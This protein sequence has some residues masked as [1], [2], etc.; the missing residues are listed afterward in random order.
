M[1]EDKDRSGKWILEHQGGAILRLGGLTGYTA[2]R[3]SAA[4]LHVPKRL[5]DGLLEV[6]FP[7]RAEPALVVVEVS[8]YPERRAEEQ[9]LQDALM[10][11]L[12]RGVL[13]EVITLVLHPKGNLRVTGTSELVS[14]QSCCE[15][16]FS[17]RV[18]NL[19]ELSGEELLA[20]NDVGLVPWVPLTRFDQPPEVMLQRCRERI[21]RQARPEEHSSMLVVSQ[22]LAQLRYNVPEL[23]AIFGGGQSMFEIES[24]L[25]KE[26]E[27]RGALQGRREGLR[28]VLEA[29]FGSVP[30]DLVAHLK[31]IHSATKLRELARQAASSND[32]ESFRVFL[33]SMQIG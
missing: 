5:P 6:T 4:E 8:T 16:R 33:A 26:I 3:L 18:V 23:L 19:W 21:D 24:P 30:D 28:D 12:D 31:T 11:Y 15:L 7:D 27:D 13:P 32:I 10:V 20:A 9:A 1:R 25:L 17:W 14:R 29:R 22:I 2:W